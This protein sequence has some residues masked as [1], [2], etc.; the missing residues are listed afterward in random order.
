MSAKNKLKIGLVLDSS[1]DNPDG[2]QQYVIDIGEWLRGNG[3]DVHYL[4]GETLRSD[5]VNVRSLSRNVN[6]KFNGNKTNVPLPTRKSKLKKLLDE[7]QFDVLHI[8]IP[9]SPFMAHRLVLAAKKRTVIFGTFHVA[10]YSGIVTFGTKLLGFWLRSSLKKF[11]KIVSTSMASAA[12]AKK[13]FSINTEILPCV[14]NYERFNRAQPLKQYNDNV[15]TILFLGRLVK[16]KGCELLIEAVSQ[17]KN[18]KELPKYR[19]LICGSGPLESH[20]RHLAA[21]HN[22][23]DVISFEGFIDEN[24]KQDFYASAD[25]S[26]FPSSGGESFGIVLLEAMA[27]GHA[28]VLAGNNPGYKS[29]MS[30]QPDLL[31]DT[32]DSASLEDK[33]KYYLLNPEKRIVMQK[34]GSSYSKGFDVNIVGS[35]LIDLYRNEIDKK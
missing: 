22:L 35:K 9:H 27:S 4:V 15:V 3:H 11:D 14:F 26:V 24:A 30:S 2:V 23:E 18:N 25:I 10:A 31:F 19:V 8:Q 28:V 16:R 7:E 32:H 6:V 21:K 17:F 1:L 13:T 12:F 29:V 34:W 5:L 20:L 33:L